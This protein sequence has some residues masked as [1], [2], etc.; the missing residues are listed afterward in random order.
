MNGTGN[1]SRSLEDDCREES[2][3]DNG[4]DSKADSESIVKQLKFDNIRAG[5]S[6]EAEH[7]I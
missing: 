2:Y 1:T 7:N 3:E 6:P 4:S 5:I